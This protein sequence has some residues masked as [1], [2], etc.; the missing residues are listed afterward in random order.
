MGVERSQFVHRWFMLSWNTV[1]G[2]KEFCEYKCCRCIITINNVVL[3]NIKFKSNVCMSLSENSV[4]RLACPPTPTPNTTKE[5]IIQRP[6][7]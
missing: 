1:K 2:I 4:S 3:Q 7:S 5:V 6:K